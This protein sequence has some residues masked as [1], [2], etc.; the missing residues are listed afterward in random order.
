MKLSVIVTFYNLEE[1]VDDALNSILMQELDFKYE[2]LIGDDG[3]SDKTVCKIREWKK[4]YPDIIRVFRMSRDPEADYNRI[5]RAS[6]LR[7]SLLGMAKGEY[8]TFLDGDDYYT[9]KTKFRKQIEILDSNK[10][11]DCVACAHNVAIYKQW[12]GKTEILNK[13]LCT[14]IINPEKYWC[15]YYFHI[16]SIVYRNIFNNL[17]NTKLNRYFDDN[18]ITFYAL[19]FGSVFYLDE[20]MAHYRQL[21]D[22]IWNS[23]TEMEKSILNLIDYDIEI[24]INK[25]MKKESI[26]RHFN[27][28]KFI[29]FN[30]KKEDLSKYHKLYKQAQWD[31]CKMCLRFFESDSNNAIRKVYLVIVYKTILLYVMFKKYFNLFNIL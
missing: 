29:Y 18:L 21:K 12:N 27:D 11:K 19:Q 30:I 4:R 2:I 26:I 14:G 7:L 8:I 10:Y 9:C 16:S 17:E 20:V 23:K 6:K 28:I 5:F 25:K 1:Y 24:F 31:K 3:S 15:N 22:S 13:G